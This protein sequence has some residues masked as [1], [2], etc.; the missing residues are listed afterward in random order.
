MLQSFHHQ[1][2]SKIGA[3]LVARL[4]SLRNEH[5]IEGMRRFGI[6]PRNE[7]LGIR[8]TTLRALGRLL[9]REIMR[10]RLSCGPWTF[11]RH[12]C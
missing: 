7:Q 2:M 4:R 3:E 8:V 1:A 10:W 5:N 6:T 9:H 11:S 12:G